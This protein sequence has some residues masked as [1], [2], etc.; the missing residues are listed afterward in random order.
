MTLNPTVCARSRYVSYPISSPMTGN[1]YPDPEKA[2]GIRFFAEG[3]AATFTSVEK[4]AIE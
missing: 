3:G 2:T 1:V 4:Y